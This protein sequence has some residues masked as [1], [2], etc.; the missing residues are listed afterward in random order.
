MEMLD[1]LRRSYGGLLNICG[2]FAG[3]VLFAVMCLVIAN[4][5]MRYAFN[6]PIAGTL[7]LTE[8][9][10]PLVIFMSLA[11]TQFHGGHIRVVLLT[12]HLPPR[13]GRGLR[14]LALLVGVGLF[15]WAAW[16]TFGMAMKSMAFNEMERGSIRFP[17]WPIKMTVFVGL[18][19][20]AIQFLIDAIYVA[21]GGKLPDSEEV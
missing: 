6:A 9:A 5:A 15:A 19:L 13:A 18:S 21:A 16:A 14:V 2:I 3:V 4:V 17:L 8:S 11:V 20:L 12:Q 1:K 7:E 10:L